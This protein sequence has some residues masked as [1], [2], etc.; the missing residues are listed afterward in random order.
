MA[1]KGKV[2][3]FSRMMTMRPLMLFV[4]LSA[5]VVLVAGN[6]CCK[7]PVDEGTRLQGDHGIE[8]KTEKPRSVELPDGSRVLMGGHSLLLLSKAFG[9]SKRELDLDGE[10]IFEIAAVAGKPFVVHTRLLEIEALGT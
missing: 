4:C 3:S 1:G 6:I 5:G 2:W 8:N 9:Q 10:A 7:G